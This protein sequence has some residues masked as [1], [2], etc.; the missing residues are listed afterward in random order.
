V[1]ANTIIAWINQRAPADPQEPI[2]DTISD[3]P[4]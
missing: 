3:T 1:D 4:P 2:T